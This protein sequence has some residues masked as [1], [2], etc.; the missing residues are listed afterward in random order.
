MTR[1]LLFALAILCATSALA[2]DKNV[3]ARIGAQKG[4]DFLVQQSDAWSSGH[5]CYGCHV[6]AVTLEAFVIGK[7]NQYDIGHAPLDRMIRAMTVGEGGTRGQGGL[8][9]HQTSLLAPSKAFGGAA[10]AHYDAHIRGDARDDLIQTGRELLAFQV[11][12][13]RLKGDYSNGPVAVGDTQS[14][15]QAVQT[16]RQIYARTA[17]DKW[18]SPIRK[19]EAYLTGLATG[20][21]QNPP[22]NL[23]ELNYA[24]LGLVEAGAGLSEPTVHALRGEILER[25]N[26]DGGFS[27][28]KGRPSAA[29]ATGQAVYTLRRLGMADKDRAVQKGTAWLLGHQQKDGG[30]SH[31]G[32]SKAEAMWGVLGLVSLD[33]VSIEVAGLRDGMHVDDVGPIKVRADDNQAAGIQKITVLLDDNPIASGATPTLDV[34]LPQ[35]WRREGLHFV[36]VEATNKKGK[37]ARRRFALY[38][39]DAI[40]TELGS[41]YQAGKTTVTYRDIGPAGKTGYVDLNIYATSTKDGLAGRGKLIKTSRQPRKPGPGLVVWDGKTDAGKTVKSGRYYA[42]LVYKDG[43]GKTRHSVEQLFAHESEADAKKRYGAVTGSL[44]GAGR[45]MANTEV[46]LVDKLGNVVQRTRSTD[47]GQYRFKN[48]DEGEYQVRIKKEGWNAPAAAPVQSVAGEEAEA[49]AELRRE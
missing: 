49:D 10:F 45:A 8:S 32:S 25:Q 22:S 37:T 19:A 33:V 2:A 1:P 3:K 28:D 46:E 36:E 29:F 35:T 47:Q 43:A 5:A 41:Q 21:S 24:A 17:D 9:Y 38:V 20:Y 15:Y 48:V 31:A 23:Q 42:E 16:W 18:L 27:F 14:T 44:K 7:A 4:L 30:W 13:G 26:P 6:H 34:K 39:G 12:D 40:L 11:A